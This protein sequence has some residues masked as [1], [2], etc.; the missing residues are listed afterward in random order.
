MGRDMQVSD[1]VVIAADAQT[2]YDQVADPVQMSRWS[3]ENTGATTTSRRT[4]RCARARS[5]T[6]R[7]SV[8]EPAGAP[9]A[10]S[11]LRNRVAGSR[12]DVRK[13]GPRTPFIPGR[14]A[15]W[16]YTFEPV[17][18]GTRVTETWTDLRRELA[19]LGG[20]DLRQDRDRWPAVLRLPAPQHQAHPRGDEG[21]LRGPGRLAVSSPPDPDRTLRRGQVHD[22]AALG[23]HD[24]AGLDQPTR[25]LT[26][27]LHERAPAVRRTD[28]TS[29][30]RGT[31]R[32][33]RSALVEE[34]E[35]RA[36]QL[37]AGVLRCAHRT[38]YRATA[39]Q[40]HDEQ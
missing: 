22:L 20:R 23:D 12:F 6:A 16:E 18:E 32:R 27:R 31:D 3:P 5:S 40:G 38:P 24:L 35:D 2:I 29:R 34:R 21:R 36:L 13:I 39:H 14:I 7:T 19:G 28:G 8:D 30:I 25:G 9:S 33:R 37:G 11:R 15:S 4:H 1:S 17:D 26:S 10:W